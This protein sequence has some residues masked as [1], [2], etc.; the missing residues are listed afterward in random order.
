M[1]TTQNFKGDSTELKFKAAGLP[2]FD[3]TLNSL[4]ELFDGGYDSEKFLL[5][6][7][8]EGRMPYSQRI[9]REVFVQFIRKALENFPF[10]GSFDSYIFILREIFGLD[11]DLI[12]DVEEPGKLSIAVNASSDVLYE[13][14]VREYDNG[15]YTFFNLS[16]SDDDDIVYKGLSGIETEAELYLLFAEIMPGGIVPTISLDYFLKSTFYGEDGSGA[17]D[18]LTSFDD[19][20][21]FIEV[22]GG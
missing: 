8:D 20:I 9:K 2:A 16:T 19:N 3:I 5:M 11:T 15:V 6:L 17:F 7:Y 22:L 14:I 13:A 12:F 4:K 1:I 21:I 10:I 18:I